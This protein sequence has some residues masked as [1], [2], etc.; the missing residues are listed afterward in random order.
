[1]QPDLAFKRAHVSRPL[2]LLDGLALSLVLLQTTQYDNA[3]DSHRGTVLL[4][5][6][7]SLLPASLQSDDFISELFGRR[8]RRRGRRCPRRGRRL[9][10][11][12]EP[13]ER[14][15]LS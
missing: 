4:P 7:L 8:P 10:R 6:S 1:M 5:L 12:R 11:R 9:L 15:K 13:G 2:H 3:P 14:R